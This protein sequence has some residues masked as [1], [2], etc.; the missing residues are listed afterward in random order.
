MGRFDF[1]RPI[2]SDI[3]VT[4]VVSKD[5]NDIRL[6]GGEQGR[7]QKKQQERDSRYAG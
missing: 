2:T 7:A 1:I 5:E 6:V 3:T 4:K